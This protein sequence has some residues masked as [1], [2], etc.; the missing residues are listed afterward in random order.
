MKQ[1]SK[2]LIERK[3]KQTSVQPSVLRCPCGL[4]RFHL[5]FL[6]RIILGLTIFIFQASPTNTLFAT[7]PPPEKKYILHHN[8]C[9]KISWDDSSVILRRNENQRFAPVM[10]VKLTTRQNYNAEFIK[11]NKNNQDRIMWCKYLDYDH[12]L[13]IFEFPKPLFQSEVRYK[14]M[15]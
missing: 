12:K 4:F 11:R 15:D 2:V 8:D 9:L 3:N 6:W 13:T 10:H 14:P 7:P 1:Y 5:Q